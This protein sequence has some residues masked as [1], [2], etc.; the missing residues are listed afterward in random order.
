MEWREEGTAA[1][2]GFVCSGCGEHHPEMPLAFRSPAPVNWLSEDLEGD[3]DSELGSDQCV[4]RGEEFYVLG[5]I[6]VPVREDDRVFE[7]G[8]WVSL[9]RENFARSTEVWTREGRE[10]EPPVFGWL[11]TDLPTY[12]PTTVNL[13]TMVHTRE[14]GRRPLVELEPTD[15]PLAIEQRNGITTDTLERRVAHLL[16]AP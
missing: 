9:S 6:Q 7:W 14:V 2:A 12:V 4:I 11:S 5:L 8:V 16:H 3:P 1:A 10:S 13:K 15:H